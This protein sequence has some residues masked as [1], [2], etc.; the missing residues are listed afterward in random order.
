MLYEVITTLDE[1]RQTIDRASLALA[2]QIEEASLDLAQEI[3][4]QS[5]KEDI[6]AQS[7]ATLVARQLGRQ[8]GLEVRTR[9]VG[10]I[11]LNLDS[12]ALV[13]GLTRLSSQLQGD[14]LPA[15]GLAVHVAPATE[16]TARLEIAWD[17]PMDKQKLKA[18]HQLAS[19]A[20]QHRITSYN[21]CYTK[22]LRL[23][24]LQ[25]FIAGA[26]GSVPPVQRAR[27]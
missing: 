13:Q 9:V 11:W 21:V 5:I 24:R 4:R 26:R 2:H 17:G 16:M 23:H 8:T 10:D 6:S 3:T 7:L 27:R 22:L 1:L 12:Y 25:V 19:Q 14:S 20:D 18:W 15:V